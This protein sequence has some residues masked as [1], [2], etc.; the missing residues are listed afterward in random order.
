MNPVD[1]NLG[2]VAGISLVPG[3]EL[4][5]QNRLNGGNCRRRLAMQNASHE[6]NAQS[7]SL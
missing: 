5:K 7:D 6:N 4:S 3:D 2:H 1:L